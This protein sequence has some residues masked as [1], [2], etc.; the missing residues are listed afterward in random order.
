MVSQRCL[1]CSLTFAF[2]SASTAAFAASAQPG[3]YCVNLDMSQ[4]ASIELLLSQ[5]PEE[6]LDSLVKLINNVYDVAEN[7]MWKSKG[8]RTNADEVRSI[9]EQRRLLVAKLPN[10]K[11]VGSVKVERMEKAGEFGMLVVDPEARSQGIGG[12]LVEAAEDWAK[13]QGFEEMQL[14]LL[15]PRTWQQPSKEFNKLWYTRLGYIPQHT[16]PFEQDYPEFVR[17]LAA[18]CDFTIWRKKLK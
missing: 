5:P 12:K 15:T 4:G 16:E 6:E 13:E 8:L 10:N 1:L 7:G 18:D 14:E 11:F 2:L 3:R 17:F 9:I